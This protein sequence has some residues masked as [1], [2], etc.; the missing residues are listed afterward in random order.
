MRQ[1]ESGATRDNDQNKF[2][3]GG[4]ISPLVLAAYAQYMHG[5]RIQ[6][7]GQPRSSN[8]WKKG[9][10]RA[11]YFESGLRHVM[12]WWLEVDGYASREGLEAALCGVMFNC[13]GYLHEV[14]REGALPTPKTTAWYAQA[15]TN[16]IVAGANYQDQPS[17]PEQLSLPE[18]GDT[19]LE[20]QHQSCDAEDELCG[21]PPRTQATAGGLRAAIHGWWL[22]RLGLQG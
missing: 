10:P 22:P 12:D 1:F 8:N 6:A 11:A 13:M 4:F 21:L 7:D 5:H 19:P 16:A 20:C 14:L 18:I 2:D 17:E 3:Y 15:Y 9:M